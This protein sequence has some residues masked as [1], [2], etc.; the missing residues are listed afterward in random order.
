[1]G[2]D[3]VIDLSKLLPLAL[4]PPLNIAALGLELAPKVPLEELTPDLWEDWVKTWRNI[5]LDIHETVLSPYPVSYEDA[6]DN[7]A[8]YLA[9]SS[10]LSVA[11]SFVNVGKILM[12]AKMVFKKI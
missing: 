12:M 2:I 11:G 3:H 5:L 10:L 6:I 4:P 1:M 9:K 7:A 8:N